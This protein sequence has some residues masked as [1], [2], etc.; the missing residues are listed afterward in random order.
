MRLL[1]DA[2]SRELAGHLDAELEAFVRAA[3][4]PEFAERV[5]AFLRGKRPAGDP[6]AGRDTSTRFRSGSRT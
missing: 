3:A 5:A 1:R 2:P 4:R 6:Q